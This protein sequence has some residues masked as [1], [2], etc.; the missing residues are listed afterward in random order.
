MRH[1]PLITAAG[2]HHVDVE[3]A[4]VVAVTGEGNP[5]PVR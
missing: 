5:P 1:Q 3:G 4:A 2:I